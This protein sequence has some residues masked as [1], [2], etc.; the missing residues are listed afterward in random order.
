MTT[1]PRHHPSVVDDDRTWTIA[2]DVADFTPGELLVEVD[3]DRLTVTGERPAIG[4]LAIR[5]HLDESLRLPHGLDPETA[6]AFFDD[7]VLRIEVPKQRRIH[8]VIPVQRAAAVRI[9]AD[10]T[11][12]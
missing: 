8:R 2:L 9:N 11:P 5:E 1:A 10:A 12:C 4:P 6:R 7:G 3:R